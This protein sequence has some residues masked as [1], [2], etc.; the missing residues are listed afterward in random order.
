MNVNTLIR[1]AGLS[2]S[3]E[4]ANENPDIHPEEMPE[5]CEHFLCALRGRDRE[6][7][8]HMST[9]SGEGPPDAQE[10][11]RYLGAVTIEFEA[12]EDVT[13]WADEFGFDPEHVHT[14][15]AFEAVCRLS[16][17]LWLLIGDDMYE[18]LRRGM[19]IE[20]AVDIAWAG[21]V[22]SQGG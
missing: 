10:A 13:E 12:C 1:R 4:P 7:T 2:L 6:M 5:D 17:D 20:Q 16:R 22:R 11:L 18:E 15:D 14:S 19:E 3:S 9:V 21:Y 8:F